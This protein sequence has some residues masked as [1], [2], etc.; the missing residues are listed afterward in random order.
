MCIIMWENGWRRLHSAHLQHAEAVYRE[1]QK[2]SVS[3]TGGVM[4]VCIYEWVCMYV[5][6]CVSVCVCVCVFHD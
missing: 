3:E 1:C 4:Y 2:L 5:C 6:G